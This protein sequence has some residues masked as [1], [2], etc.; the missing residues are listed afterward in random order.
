ML[1]QSPTHWDVAPAEI[2][3]D[4]DEVH[5]WRILPMN[6]PSKLS[7]Y[8]K[9]LQEEELQRFERFY[10]DENRFEYLWAHGALRVVLSRYLRIAPEGLRFATNPY[11]R[12][13]IANRIPGKRLFFSL[14]HAEG[15][16]LLAVS[17]VEAVGVDVE[18]FRKMA[19]IES[20]AAHHFSENEIRKLASLNSQE[21]QHSFFRCWTRKEAVVKA[22]GFGLSLDINQLEVTLL[23][24]EEPAVVGCRWDVRNSSQWSL[25]DV[26]PA[27]GYFGAV[28]LESPQMNLSRFVLDEQAFAY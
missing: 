1:I 4:A 2:S 12:P 16:A 23:P 13:Y 3:I 17:R 15:L 7:T 18:R 28:A 21:Q 10:R 19:D 14:S 8:L 6:V 5:V 9:L 20:I 24:S 26:V 27:P 11:G 25:E 22:T